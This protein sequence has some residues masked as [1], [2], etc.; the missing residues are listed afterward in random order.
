[1]KVFEFV[2][3]PC[4]LSIRNT[5]TT[6]RHDQLGDLGVIAWKINRRRCPPFDAKPERTQRLNRE[7]TTV[8]Y[9]NFSLFSNGSL[10]SKAENYLFSKGKSGAG[11]GPPI[12]MIKNN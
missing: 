9:P 1:M 8:Q 7:T 12:P 2:M 6:L 5:D 11:E 4:V 10:L 3:F